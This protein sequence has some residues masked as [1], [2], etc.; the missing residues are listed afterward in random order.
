ML[1]ENYSGAWNNLSCVDYECIHQLTSW[2]RVLSEELTG[3]KLVKSTPFHA[4]SPRPILILSSQLH[5][6]LPSGL[7]PSGLPTITLCALPLYMQHAQPISS[8]FDHLNNIWW[9]V[10]IIKLLIMQFSAL[11]CHLATLQ[12]ECL[13]QN[14]ILEHSQP[15]FPPSMWG[16]KFHTH[17]QKK[18]SRYFTQWLFCI[19]QVNFSDV[20][21]T[22]I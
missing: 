11:P 9:A 20:S 1:S 18:K 21:N 7:F 15:T 13:P 17:T 19:S 5:L 2:S 4:I 10:Q 3:L 6:G 8:W 22:A 14:A 16:T 12:T